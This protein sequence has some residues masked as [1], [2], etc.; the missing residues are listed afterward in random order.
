MAST[1]TKHQQQSCSSQQREQGKEDPAQKKT[2]VRK[3]TKTGCLTCRKRRI[4]CDEGRPICNNCIKSKRNCEGYNQ[5]VVFKDPLGSHPGSYGPVVFPPGSGHLIDQFARQNISSQGSLA[6]IAPKPPSVEFYQHQA[7]YD[8]HL[9]GQHNRDHSSAYVLNQGHYPYGA[10]LDEPNPLIPFAPT[11]RRYDDGHR[12]RYP[13]QPYNSDQAANPY[14]IALAGVGHRPVSGERHWEH[15]HHNEDDSMPESDDEMADTRGLVAPFVNQISG[16]WDGTPVRAFS[17]FAQITALSD[18]LSSPQTSELRDRGMRAIFMHFIK[19][20]GP[21]MSMYERHPFD[22]LTHEP[23]TEEHMIG[24]SLWSYTFP[25]ISLQHPSLLYAMLALGSLQIAKLQHVPPTA[26]MKHYSL[27]IRRIAKN[28]RSSLRRTQ[29]ATLAATLLL[30]YFE[31]WSSDH[32]KWCT[33]LFGARILLREI[34]LKEM[35]RLCL[36]AK[37]RRE[38]EKL[39]EQR[40]RMHL[41]HSPNVARGAFVMDVNYHVLSAITGKR[42]TA[43]DYGLQD[44][45]LYHDPGFS[46]TNYDIEKY[47]NLR[48]L[49]W[50]YCKMDVYQSMLG[51]TRLFMEYECWTQCP[52]RAPLSRPEAVY[53]TYDHLMLLLGRLVNFAS[54]D[55]ERKRKSNRSTCGQSASGSPPPFPGMLPTQGIFQVPMGFSPP[56]ETSPRS[57]PLEDADPFLDQQAALEEWE[58]LRQAFDIFESN[59]GPDFQ[60]DEYA[61]VT[62]SPF[63]PVLQYRSY[64]VAGIWMNIYMGL[65]HLYR[66]HPSMPPAAMQAAGLSAHHTAEYAI[67]LGRIAA[68]LAGDCTKVGEISTLVGAAFIESAFCLFVAAVQFQDEAQRRWVVQRMHDISRLTGWQ[69]AKQIA[70]GC[71]SGWI[72]A[73]QLGRGPE[74]V[75]ATDL[76]HA[77]TSVW[78]N[79]RKIDRKIHELDSGEDKRLVLAKT[80]RA[81][82]ALGLLGVEDDLA[83]LDLHDEGLR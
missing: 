67:R 57:E 81:H 41:F 35:S 16:S 51:G 14:P 56:R 52:P 11:T 39:Q 3:R 6:P 79:P 77:P 9:L 82:Y 64:S 48:D 15:P 63:G 44:E 31:V 71:E 25:V 50:W 72:K 74:Y 60:P 69:S 26:A 17:T 33:H 59:L 23:F 36:P 75:R 20:T 30:A 73:A 29:P 45:H 1:A 54:N 18:Y 7:L 34:P 80:E 42:V 49:F 38:R 10:C 83:V 61:G 24:R 70:D 53:G 21:S 68:G 43:E 62:G 66:S 78:Q 5:R 46:T 13:V 65:I 76:T 4:K 27:A 32:T 2:N 37:R 55:L 58:S 40:M 19:V 22:P 28:V 47:E 8:P 12:A